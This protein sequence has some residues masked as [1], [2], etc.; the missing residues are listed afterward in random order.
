MNKTLSYLGLCRRAGKLAAGHDAVFD[1]LRTGKARL[2]AVTADASPRH[3]ASLRA[4]APQMTVL[5]LPYTS[6][7]LEAAVGR[8]I[9]ILAVNDEGLAEAIK[10]QFEEEAIY[11]SKIQST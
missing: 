10:K 1:A 5:Q 9:C 3:L 7:E 4:V 6:T 8:K 2:C 11:D